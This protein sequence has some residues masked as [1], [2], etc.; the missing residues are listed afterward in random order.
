MTLFDSV[1]VKGGRSN[2]AE[3]IQ[4]L[5]TEGYQVVCADA[6]DFNLNRQFDI[7]V[8]GEL[9]E[10]LTN[11]GG[12]L[13]C[14]RQHLRAEGKLVLT[15]PNAIC[16][17]YF[18]QNIFKGHELDNLDHCC[19]YSETTLRCLLKRYGFQIEQVVY[20]PELG[21]AGQGSFLNRF[22]WWGRQALQYACA[23]VR[24]SL[25]HHFIAVAR[26]E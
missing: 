1:H 4:K 6:T 15:M 24:P 13:T 11:P 8:A 21:G 16:L 18:I 10:H 3:H 19:L 17:N 23:P 12:F 9:M 22:S 5:Q 2:E 20:Y 26:Q 25:C 14:A 7:I